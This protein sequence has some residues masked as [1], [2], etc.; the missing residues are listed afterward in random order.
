MS[1]WMH[2]REQYHFVEPLKFPKKTAMSFCIKINKISLLLSFVHCVCSLLQQPSWTIQLEYSR[3]MGISCTLCFQ[4]NCGE[5][6]QSSSAEMWESMKS[7]PSCKTRERE[8]PH[9]SHDHDWHKHQ[10]GWPT[11]HVQIIPG[12]SG[13]FW[14][15]C[16]VLELFFFLNTMTC[17]SHVH[18]GK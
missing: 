1:H 12:A 8:A 5:Q 9:L 18:L 10:H 7:N 14:W 16:F 15:V 11:E 4:R 17:K 6:R 13:L 3:F 2:D